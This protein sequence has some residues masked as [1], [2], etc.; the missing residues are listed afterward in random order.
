MADFTGL[1]DG[2]ANDFTRFLITEIGVACIPPATFFSPEH[3]HLAR[4][5]V[6]FA[7]CKRDD[8]LQSASDRLTRLQELRRPAHDR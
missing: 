5:W 3:R 2:D 8:V 7:F 6:R 4:Q 1:H